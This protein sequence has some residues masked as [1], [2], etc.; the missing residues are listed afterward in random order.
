MKKKFIPFIMAMTLVLHVFAFYAQNN[1]NGNGNGNGNQNNNGNGNGNGNKNVPDDNWTDQRFKQWE[2]SL[3]NA[4]YPLLKP[5]KTHGNSNKSTAVSKSI[6]STTAAISTI[7]NNGDMILRSATVVNNTYIPDSGS[8]KTNY[9]VGEI[10]MTSAVSPTGAVTYNV[11]IEIYPGIH[12]MQPHLSI[13]YNSMGGNGILGTGWS[14][15]G[16]SSIN[17]G[18]QSIWYDGKSQGIAMTN[19]DAFYLDGMRLIKLSATTAQIKYQSEQGNIKVTANL[20]GT[21]VKYFDVFL[22]DGTKGTYGS[23]GNTATSYLEYPLTALSDLY[24]NTITYTYTYANNHYRISKISYANASV[25]FNYTTSNRP[26]IITTYNGGLKIQETGLLQS[27][28]CYYG[29][30]ILRTYSFTCTTQ[31]DVSLLTSITLYSYNGNAFNPLKFYYGEGNTATT[32]TFGKTQLLQWYSWTNPNQVTLRKG[33]FDC[34]YNTQNDALIILPYQPSYW[35]HYRNATWFRHSQNRFDNYYTGKDT[36]LFYA[37]LYSSYATPMPILLTEAGFVDIFCADLDGVRGEEI[38]KVNDVVSG[39]NDQVTFKTYSTN[40]YTGL[41]P[42]YATRT[43]TFSTVLTDADG[44]KSITPKFYFPGDFNG[45]G[46]TEIFAVS[47][48]YPFGWT[49]HPSKNY[50]FN[51]EAGTKLYEGQT[52]AYNQTFLGVQN[53]DSA[54]ISNNSDR[55]YVFDYDGDGKSDLCLIN[56]TGTYIYTFDISG[57]TYSMRQIATYSGLK[58]ADLVGRNLLIGEFNGDGKPDFLLSP[59]LSYNDWYIY[60]AMGNGQFEKTAAIPICTR[61]AGYNY[62]LQDVNSDG[63]TD[64]LEYN[65]KSFRNYRAKNGGFNA[66]ESATTFANANSIFI[67]T[68]ISTGYSYHQLIALKDGNVTLYKYPRNDMKEKLLTGS[69]TSLG[70][71]NKNYYRMLDESSSGIYSMGYDAVYPY[72]NFNGS[73]FVLEARELY[74]NKTK[75]ESLSYYYQNAVIHNQGLGFR[76]F[77]QI[78]TYDNIR[79]RSSYQIFDPYN[80][81][82]KKEDDSP[83]SNTKNTYTVSVAAN[84]I[85]NITLANQIVLGKAKNL[86]DTTTYAYDTYGNPTTETI[87]Y[88]G[89]ITETM[90]NSYFNNTN[91]VRYLIGFMTNRTKTINR[92]GATWQDRMYIQTHD[93][94]GQPT[95]MIHYANGNQTAYETFTYDARGCPA[96]HGMKGYTSA[97]T[98]TTTYVYDAYGRET[99]ETNPM[100]FNTTYDYNASNGS[101]ADVKNHKG[102]ATTYAYDVFYRKTGYTTPDSITASTVYSW[103]TLGT[104]GLYCIQQSVTGKPTTKTCYDALGRETAS[105]VTLFNSSESRTDKLYD[106]YGRLSKLSLP[107]IG[108]A[109]AYWNT[110]AYDSYDRPTSITEASGKVTSY[111]YS[112]NSVTTTKKGIASTQNFDMQGNLISVVDPAGTITYNL[113]PDGQPSSIVAPGSVAT[114]FTYDGYGRRISIVDPSAGTQSTT[115]DAAGNVASEKDANGKIISYVYDAYNRLTQKTR[116]EFNT[117]YA[118]NT[119]GLL[120]SETSGNGT[121]TAYTYDGYGRVQTE[122]ETAPDGKWLQKYYAYSAGNIASISYTSQSG[123]IVAECYYYTAGHL[124]EIRLNGGTSIWKLTAANAFGQPTGVT[125]GSFNRTYG[126]SAYGLPTGRTAGSFQNFTYSFDATKGN[127]TY[128]KDNVRNIQENFSYDNLNRLT[129]YAGKSATYNVNGNINSRSEIGAFQ[130]AVAGKPYA[131]SGVTTPTNLIPQRNQTSHTPRSS[132]RLQSPKAL[133]QTISLMLGV[134]SR[135]AWL[136]ASVHAC[137]N[138]EL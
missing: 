126:Y 128:R 80:Y 96:T 6:T 30:S 35:Q 137:Q 87:K 117:A 81:C 23:T 130:Y 46:K 91:E 83:A 63:L 44:G 62:T 86:T 16:L 12:G 71:V 111:S 97:N 78:T 99:K 24:G 17:R 115:F 132:V 41:G 69:I 50:L 20:N 118:Y 92:N 113:R 90:S 31:K 133:T 129:G 10:P 7:A 100:G 105:T 107:F 109:A 1:G 26:D 2:D 136:N 3:V 108:T 76:G 131:L 8:V 95:V 94:L 59:K 40:I 68:D 9:A 70:V 33:K 103:T 28:V 114:S 27:I 14:V 88:G 38:V 74:F 57:T 4:M 11:P 43:F 56:A 85:A 19:D 48:N 29:S 13:A 60:Y 135:Y 72:V 104:N 89:G 55:L 15:S 47:C 32:Y 37:G 119:D 138:G 127:L 34:D 93:S 61:S 75:T 121:S 22:P 123:S 42:K 36:I 79:G 101:L 64:I 82:V 66:V 73:L 106:T 58:L 134:A 52:L 5:Q 116:P 53:Q 122:K 112:G 54:T 65:S 120:A 21:I 98:L 102:Q 39:S 124:T 77:G 49:D 45:D 67:P 18:N 125:T 25:A 110:Y 84:K 51:L